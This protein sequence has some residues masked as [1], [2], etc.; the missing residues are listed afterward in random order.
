VD[1]PYERIPLFVKAGTILPVGK[2]IQH[3]GESQ[4]N[5]LLLKVYTGQDAA[6]TLYEDEGTNYDY[7]K[8]N[9]LT[10][11]IEYHEKTKTLTIRDAK[12][13]YKNMPQSRQFRIEWITPDGVKHTNTSIQ[14]QG[15]LTNVRF[16]NK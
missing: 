6:F 12:G 15:K 1:A 3:T 10:I 16:D 9:Y 7:E 14:Y 11:K 2:D 4:S 5:D 8:G 13:Q